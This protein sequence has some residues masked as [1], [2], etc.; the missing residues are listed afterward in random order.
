MVWSSI[1]AKPVWVWPV[2][3][4]LVLIGLRARRD[5]VVPVFVY[6]FL[7]LL[8][9]ITA[10]NVAQLTEPLLAW[11]TFGTAYLCGVY[12][13]DQ[14]QQRF[15]VS[16][17]G[18]LVTLKGEKITLINILILFSLSFAS[19]AIRDAMPDL[20]ASTGFIVGSCLV[21]GVV[22]GSFAGRAIRIWRT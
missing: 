6:Y 22:S 13:G 19:G 1:V 5:R 12:L 21:G 4:L 2:L 14:V 17:S 11:G 18:K 7:P 20:F 9:L 3:L 10:R 16:K 8:G 15:L